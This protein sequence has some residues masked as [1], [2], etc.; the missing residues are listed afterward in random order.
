MDGSLLHLVNDPCTP[1]RMASAAVPLDL[2]L[3]YHTHGRRASYY[4]EGEVRQLLA[5]RA[6]VRTLSA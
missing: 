6:M 2:A 5:V 4:N 1:A 3:W